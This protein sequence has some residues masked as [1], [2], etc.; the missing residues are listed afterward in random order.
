MFTYITGNPN[1]I[2]SAQK[3]LS[4]QGIKFQH[5]ELDLVEI[6]SASI[7][8]I[9]LDKAQ[10]A[11]KALGVPVLVNDVGWSISALDGFPGPL[12]AIV[13]KWLTNEDF[14]NLMRGKKDRSIKTITVLTYSDGKTTKSFSNTREG[15]ILERPLGKGRIAFD[16]IISFRS[17]KKSVAQCTDEGIPSSDN[18]SSIW[19]VFI[20]WI[21]G[22]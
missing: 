1:K 18:Q 12:M 22:K 4:E 10:Q 9:S 13:H 6:Q 2:A 14:L 15:I 3:R 19:P 7:E 16:Q 11:Y 17:D 8:E 21:S 5:Q 20:E